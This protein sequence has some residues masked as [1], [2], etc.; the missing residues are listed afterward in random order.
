MLL[1]KEIWPFWSGWGQ[2]HSK[3]TVW[4][5]F[6]FQLEIY[7][8]VCEAHSLSSDGCGQIWIRKDKLYTIIYEN[9]RERHLE[10]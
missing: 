1:N 7:A 10:Y 5:Q 4:N 8:L 6:I 3:K 2:K 9:K